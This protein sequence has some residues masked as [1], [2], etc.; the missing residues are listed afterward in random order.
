MDRRVV[1]GAFF[2][3]SGCGVFGGVRVV[4][5]DAAGR[6]LWPL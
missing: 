3:C 1:R 2:G 4:P 5:V 6:G